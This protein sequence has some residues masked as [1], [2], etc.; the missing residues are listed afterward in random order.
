[1]GTECFLAGPSQTFAVGR[2]AKRQS[3]GPVATRLRAHAAHSPRLQ[4]N[5]PTPIRSRIDNAARFARHENAFPSPRAARAFHRRFCRGDE[6]RDARH[7]GRRARFQA[8]RRGWARLGA[9]VATKNLLFAS[10]NKDAMADAFEPK[11]AGQV[12]FTVLLGAK[13]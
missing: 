6:D 2:F 11:W 7:R 13:G 3:D 8:A 5:C 12:P 4:P 1:M 10:E 9:R